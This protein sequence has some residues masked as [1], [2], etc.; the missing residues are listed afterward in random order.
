[1][2][3]E[4]R[5]I[6]GRNLTTRMMKDLDWNSYRILDY[7]EGIWRSPGAQVYA[8]NAFLSKELEISERS[9]QRAL[10]R[11]EE[12]GYIQRLNTVDTQRRGIYPGGT[13]TCDPQGDTDVTPPDTG[14]TPPRQECHPSHDTGVTHKTSKDKTSKKEKEN[15][16][17]HSSDSNSIRK[18]ALESLL[19]AKC[20]EFQKAGKISP[21][22]FKYIW[23]A[24]MEKDS[25]LMYYEGQNLDLEEGFRILTH[26]AL[27]NSERFLGYSSHYDCLMNWVAKE[28]R[29]R[30]R[31]RLN[32]EAA[33]KRS[34]S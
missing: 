14:V 15:P 26:C 8:S 4:N 28:V 9:V 25:L 32:L 7:C 13:I 19:E 10:S 11:L 12:L 33:R 6:Y 34:R 27:N 21:K 18:E 29:N 20:L 24:P 17:P 31:E 30:E 1:M 16:P 23:L 22:D 5:G 3:I 2:T